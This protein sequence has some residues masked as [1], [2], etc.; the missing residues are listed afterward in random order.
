M[1]KYQLVLFLLILSCSE[2]NIKPNLVFILTDEQRYDT[3][4]HYG[5]DKIITPN[6]NK[7]GDEAVVFENAYVAQPVCS[8][9]RSSIMTG[10]YP[11]QTGV[12]QNKI[13]LSEDIATFPQLLGKHSYETAYIGKWH[14]GKELDPSHGFNQVISMEDGYHWKEDAEAGITIRYSDYHKWLIEKG[15]KPD[16]KKR[17]TFSRTFC[18]NLPYEH[19]KSSFIDNKA[20][21]F[22]DANKDNQFILY[23]GFLEPHTPVNGPFNDLHDINDIELDNTYGKFVPKNEPLRNKIIRINETSG[24]VKLSLKNETS[25]L[26]EQMKKYWGLV[27]QVDLSVGKILKKLESLGLDENTIVVFTSDN[28]P[29][30]S[31]GEHAGS[32]GIYREGKGTAWEGGQRVPCIVKYPKK[33]KKGTVIDEPLM[34][35]DWLPTFAN[36]TNSQMSSNKIDGKNI[37]PLLISETS[38]SPHEALYFYYRANELHAVRS[39]EWKLYFPRSYR[40]LNGRNGGKDGIP[41]KYEQNVVNEKQLYNLK[42]DPSELNNILNDHPNIV[43]KLEKMGNLARYDLGDKL[44]NVEGIGTRDVGTIKL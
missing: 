12:I 10:L 8:P 22:I 29:W 26:K 11:H 19:T 36:V 6:L 24:G 35:I 28:G 18:T 44:T 15:Y 38:K 14:L 9:N 4:I 21:E 33:I 17:G 32:S 2:K 34:G 27:H 20:I 31:Y 25:I 7:L 40:S 39:G 3:S 13:P 43:S 30:L 41:V 37:W 23:L 42:E 16:S 1:L 5:N